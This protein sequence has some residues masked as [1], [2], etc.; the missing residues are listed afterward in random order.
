MG[1]RLD[2]D[3]PF[4][5]IGQQGPSG[6]QGEGKTVGAAARVAGLLAPL[7]LS[8]GLGLDFGHQ[9]LRPPVGIGD[10]LLHRLVGQLHPPGQ[11]VAL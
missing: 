9:A 3:R 10:G 1:L 8:L 6:A 5:C 11:L 7:G 2:D 4:P